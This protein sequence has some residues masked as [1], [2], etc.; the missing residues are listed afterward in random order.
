MTD[1]LFHGDSYLREFEATVS[2]AV[3][4]GVVLDRTA[5]YAGGGGNP[6]IPGY[7]RS[8]D[9]STRSSASGGQEG[10]SSTALKG[11]FQRLAPG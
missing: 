8:K 2:A 6:A 1:L 3:E 11:R 4:D 5:F 9:R 7:W 10:K